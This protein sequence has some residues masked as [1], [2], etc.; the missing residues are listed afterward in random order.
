VWSVSR[1]RLDLS[2]NEAVRR[3]DTIPAK[4]NM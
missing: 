2:E 3:E 4:E 1:K